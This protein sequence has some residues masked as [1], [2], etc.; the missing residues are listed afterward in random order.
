MPATATADYRVT[1]SRP[2]YRHAELRRLLHP[3]S[4]AILGASPREG[5][6]GLRTLNNLAAFEGGVYPINEK[7]EAI[8]RH[9]C[10]AGLAALP[11]LPDCA[12]VAVAREGVEAAV[13]Q[14]V[15]A[16]VGGVIV[17]A[18]GY[19]ETGRADLVALQQ[20][21]GEQVR[22]TG[23]RLLGPNCLGVTNYAAR[24]R[25]LFG[26]MP[27]AYPLGERSIGII[28]QSGSVA[29]S[30]GQAVERGISIS[31]AIPVGNA[32][33]VGVGDLIAYL[34]EDPSCHAIACVFEGVDDAGRLIEAAELALAFDKP[35]IV[36]KM[37][38]G[39]QGAAAALSHTG[40][41]AGSAAAYRAVL[42]EAGAVMLDR[43]EDLLETAAFFAKAGRPRG[44]GAAVVLG[45]GGLGVIAADKGEAH[46][47][48]LPQPAG[49]TLEI[50]QANV[51]EFGAARNPCDVTA[52]ALNA[53]GPME[54]CADAMLADPVYSALVVVH[55]YADAFG[56]AR[57]NLWRRLAAK[58][59]KI[60]CNYWS[61]ESLV[62][63]GAIEL[64]AEPRIAT[65]R[66]FDRCFGALAAW[67]AREARRQRGARRLARYAGEA[68]AREA[69]AM[70]AD[71]PNRSLG[72]REAKQL[73]ACYGV[74]VVAEALVQSREDALRAATELGLPVV[75]KLESPDLLHKTEA[76]VVR[77]GLR[78]PEDVGVAYDEINAKARALDPRPRISGVL[79]QPML[80]AGI[81]MLVGAHNDPV[82]GPLLVVGFGGVL[83]ELLN[84]TAVA[85]PPIDVAKAQEMLRGLKGFRLLGGFR[86]AKPVSL[87]R[88]AEVISRVSEFV[89]DHAATIDELDINPLI[90]SGEQVMAVDALIVRKAPA[91]R[92]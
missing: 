45:S 75:L 41:L 44:H 84:D 89:A 55:P 91:G 40:A 73:L 9:R 21:L 90:C 70:I 37:A 58:H 30:L 34:A 24:A 15:A 66:S 72:E 20:R 77:L 61:T 8:G 25:I 13:A 19:A 11:E 56:S 38:V 49:R 36:Y 60:V 10:Y 47:V 27:E 62:G 81:E 63:H 43:M 52:L 57:V 42:E 22:G 74:P 59:D 76:G 16:G 69:A 39:A 23:T 85:R 3:R 48:P 83:V 51:P 46:G 87:E 28:A 5:S 53:E 68:A 12:V 64:E 67:Q 79:V 29:M 6:F 86:G 50:L 65:F 14:C 17:Y 82:F 33:D 1:D 31:H 88:L 78:T 92:N 18:S 4:I 7:Y 54:A 2:V 35:L 32:A 26:R 80:P 71:A